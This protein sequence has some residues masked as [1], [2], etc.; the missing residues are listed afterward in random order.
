MKLRPLLQQIQRVLAVARRGFVRRASGIAVAIGLAL[1]S[2]QQATAQGPD[3]ITIFAAASLGKALGEITEEFERATGIKADLSLAGSSLLARQLQYGAP[4]DVFFSANSAW[5]DW[6]EENELIVPQSRVDLL[7]NRLVLI[8]PVDAA[9]TLDLSDKAGLLAVLSDGP[10]AMALIDAVPAGIYGKAALQTLD[11]WDD[12]SA[13][14]AQ[15]DN[16]QSAL[17]LVAQG[18]APLGIVYETDAKASAQVQILDHLPRESHPPIIYPAAATTTGQQQA[19]LAFLSFLQGEI[20]QAIFV[21]QG[22]DVLA[23]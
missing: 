17:T 22:F 15:T 13:H 4:A 10:L 6:A 14:I 18:A 16:V 1:L 21:G 11:L 2:P 5:M 20:A 19:S 9:E 7:S 23:E 12:F 3:R 8:A